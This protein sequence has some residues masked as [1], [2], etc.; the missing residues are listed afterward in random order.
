M[1]TFNAAYLKRT[2]QEGVFIICILSQRRYLC[3]MPK[4]YYYQVWH[5]Y[6]I[7]WDHYLSWHEFQ[8]HIARLSRSY[9]WFSC[10]S[11]QI[12][13]G[14]WTYIWVCS[15][16]IVLSLWSRCTL[17][18]DTMIWHVIDFMIPSWWIIMSLSYIMCDKCRSR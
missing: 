11:Q 12:K 18:P 15:Q 1:I 17:L 3:C 16:F 14:K 9:D 2:R 13:Q 6:L 7:L 4:S 10:M 8:F 5:Q